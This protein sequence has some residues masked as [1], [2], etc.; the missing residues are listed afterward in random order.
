MKPFKVLSALGIAVLFATGC[1]NKTT[2][3]GSATP[4][5][6][7]AKPA[8]TSS[9]PAVKKLTVKAAQTQS[10]K[11]GDTDEI[12]IKIDRVSFDDAVTIRLNDLPKG[13]EAVEKEVVIPAGSNSAKVTLKASS[14]A[15][16]GEHDVKIDAKAPGIDENVQTFKLT[17]KDKG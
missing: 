13:V 5:A 12:S 7:P 2:T 15:E 4:A 14:D 1:E 17:V 3:T 16:V 9:Q 11:Q 10:I 6:N 8:V